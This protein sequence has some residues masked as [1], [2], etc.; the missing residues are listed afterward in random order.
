MPNHAT[1]VQPQLAEVSRAAMVW[2]VELLRGGFTGRIEL[3]CYNGA[4]RRVQKNQV[5]EPKNG[6]M[7]CRGGGRKDSKL[8]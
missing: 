5:W 2:I 3:E 1:D 6:E 7:V 4:V 8:E